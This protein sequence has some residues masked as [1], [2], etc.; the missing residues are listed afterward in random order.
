I[1]S[2]QPEFCEISVR[3]EPSGR[4]AFCVAGFD[5]T[6]TQQ[7]AAG[8]P[9]RGSKGS[10]GRCPISVLLKTAEVDRQLKDEKI[11]PGY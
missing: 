7:N 10:L 11:K 6:Q 2:P 4:A 3:Y 1:L 8:L 5:S 9:W